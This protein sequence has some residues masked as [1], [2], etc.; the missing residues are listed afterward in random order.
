MAERWGSGGA[1]GQLW[2]EAAPAEQGS[3]PGSPWSV[4][5]APS[6]ASGGEQGNGAG[7]AI[8]AGR[9]PQQPIWPSQGGL[10]AGGW[11][12]GAAEAA[13][14]VSS[15]RSAGGSSGAAS[16]TFAD[17]ARLHAVVQHQQ[18]QLEAANYRRECC[19][20]CGAGCRTLR[21]YP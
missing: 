4:S 6:D 2:K 16:P 14:A 5:K 9:A 1:Q 19:C 13:T 10:D 11:A 8:L 21:A 7:W 18:Q 20:M 17:T 15:A 12:A 3:S